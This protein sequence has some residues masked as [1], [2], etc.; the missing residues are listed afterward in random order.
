MWK[1]SQICPYLYVGNEEIS[2]DSIVLAGQLQE[3]CS[4][5]ELAQ[6]DDN[7]EVGGDV[8]DQEPEYVGIVSQV[9]QED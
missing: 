8:C 9:P 4:T 6:Q 1:I 5:G 2:A 7:V 3:V